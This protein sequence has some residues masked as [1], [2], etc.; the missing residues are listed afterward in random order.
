VFVRDRDGTDRAASVFT[1]DPSTAAAMIGAHDPSRWTIEPTF[2]ELRCHLG[3]ETPRGWC[4]STVL[5]AASGRFG[6]YWVVAV[7][8]H[9]RPEG[10]RSGAVEWP[11]KSTVTFSDAVTAARRW[12]WCE[13]FPTG[14][15][16]RGPTETSRGAA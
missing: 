11:G 15:V 10:K 16:W 8:D 5:R 7:L 2:Q 3:L 4:R 13:C 12:L 6:L 1:T 14:R 9:T